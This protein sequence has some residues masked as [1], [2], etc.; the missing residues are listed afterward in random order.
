M[1]FT[2]KEKADECLILNIFKD[3]IAISVISAILFFTYY[4]VISLVGRH[5]LRRHYFESVVFS[6]KYAVT[7]AN[8]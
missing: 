3:Y 6:D 4:R 5:S 2:K 7:Y 1:E 8:T